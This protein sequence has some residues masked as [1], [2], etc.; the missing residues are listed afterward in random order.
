MGD[1]KFPVL[2]TLSEFNLTA[3][4]VNAALER[5]LHQSNFL[6]ESRNAVLIGAGSKRRIRRSMASV[7]SRDAMSMVPSSRSA[8]CRR[9]LSCG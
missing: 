3:S 6:N 9:S 5:D 2:K 8:P 1:A 4:P 7:R